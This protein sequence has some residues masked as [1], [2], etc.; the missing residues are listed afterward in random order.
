MIYPNPAAGESTQVQ[1]TGLTESTKVSME[2]QT[3]AFR[4]IVEVI[5]HSEGHGTVNLTLPLKDGT[6]ADLANGLYYLVVRAQNNTLVLK[7]M[8]LR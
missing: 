8:V 3:V 5:F 2:L 4:K 6:G 7:L 1:I